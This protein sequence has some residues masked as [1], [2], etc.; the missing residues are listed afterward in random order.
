MKLTNFLMKLS[1]ETVTLELKNG[2]VLEGT[3]AGV[4]EGENQARGLELH[5]G[6][7]T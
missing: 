4:R 1:N 2:T 7:S 3:L 5:G 6:Y